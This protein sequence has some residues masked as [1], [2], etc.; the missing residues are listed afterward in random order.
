MRTIFVLAGEYSAPEGGNG[1]S[2]AFERAPPRPG[3]VPG[4]LEPDPGLDELI[5]R[6]ARRAL[7][8]T[9][10]PSL[11]AEVGHLLV[12]TMPHGE[13]SSFDRAVNLPN[14]LQRR[15]GLSGGC[16]ARFEI[17][18]SD[19]GAAVFSSAVHLLR[20]LPEE[21]TALVCAG[22]TMWGGRLA[23][24][25]VA[26]VLEEDERALGMNMIAVGDLLM[27]RFVQAWRA[28]GQQADGSRPAAEQAAEMIDGLVRRKLE[29]ATEY[30]SAL[31]SGA[32][33]LPA[34]SPWIST[35]L[36]REHVAPA[37][38]GACA[39]LLTTDEAVVGR[40]VRAGRRA[41]VVRVLGVGEG[42]ANSRL[43][44]RGEP[45]G[46]ARSIRQALHSLSHVTGTNLDFLRASAF[47]VTHDAFPSIEM[48][49]LSALGF[50]PHQAVQRAMTYWPNPYGGLTAF[51]HALGASGL[52]Q[53]AKAFHV[54]TRP[55]AH[56]PEV[57][58]ASHHV[59]LRGAAGPMHCLTTS[60][61]GPLTHVVATLLQSLP[62]RDGS[63]DAG[64]AAAFPTPWVR[65]RPPETRHRHLYDPER[66]GFPALAA[67]WVLEA[68]T[69]ARQAL[70]E[71][72]DRLLQDPGERLGALE[73]RTTLDLR[74]LPH[75]LPAAFLSQWRPTVLRWGDRA[76]PLPESFVEELLRALTADQG[77]EPSAPLARC[78]A[79][80]KAGAADVAR[81]CFPGG[82]PADK[83]A[84]AVLWA[85]LQVPVALVTDARPTHI[86]GARRLCLLA[87]SCADPDLAPL[88]SVL[89]VREAAPLPV[90]TDTVPLPGLAPPW[91]L[92]AGGPAV[93]QALL[94]ADSGELGSVL[95][96]LRR[97]RMRADE[98]K[99]VLSLASTLRAR[100]AETPEAPPPA[101]A[102]ALFSELVWSMEPDRWILARTLA[103]LAGIETDEDATPS[104]R[105]MA[106]V[107]F[108]VVGAARLSRQAYIH[109]LDEIVAGI[110]AAEGWFGG[111][112]LQFDRL[113][114]GVAITAWDDRLEERPRALWPMLVRVARD[115]Y[116]G[117]MDRGLPVRATC[118]VGPGTVVDQVQ[119]REG[120][121]GLF[122]LA[123]WRGLQQRSFGRRRASD[124]DR[125]DGRSDGI[126]IVLA[127]EGRDPPELQTEC[128]AIWAEG[129]GE[130][131][132]VV[133]GGQLEVRGEPFA[134]QIRRRPEP[135]VSGPADASEPSPRR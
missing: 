1:P 9:A 15:L 103:E 8:S 27:D 6:A 61:G 31:R 14:R 24:Q 118:C 32:Q 132:E 18:T 94:P 88:G 80:I 75:P 106:Y 38:V 23:I 126:A 2:P 40:W 117:C 39:V 51:G 25:T 45:F 115:V 47:A 44:Q 67:R 97:G 12:T 35:W 53:V 76:G 78:K 89:R 87:A 81:R 50:G 48:A 109:C 116:Q 111:A 19:A 130:R 5:Y 66:D 7:L 129:G 108:D 68:N 84:P 65:I 36:K 114:D 30:P 16:Q 122:Q 10:D 95:Q 56:L 64:L 58:E 73:G 90:A 131:L 55:P 121:A 62:A 101:A 77:E 128:D 34:D 98:M 93:T 96:A 91:C 28:A 29:L 119:G 105:R 63:L 52:V 123:A 41:R 37:S 72:S 110:R 112:R 69:G 42:D 54:F 71:A 43:A 57:D 20:G 59:D 135:R 100:L 99:A 120:G 74:G 11:A 133:G 13:D 125:A 17:G 70:R 79:L 92:P 26:R 86:A 104:T 102:R 21:A 113:R 127:C 49:F 107:E 22:Q 82:A 3:G 134:W 83:D 85:S 46:Y 33:A 124:P 60:V 4:P